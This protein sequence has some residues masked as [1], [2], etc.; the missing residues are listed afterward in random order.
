MSF[1]VSKVKVFNTCPY[2]YK[3]KY[4]DKL[5]PLPDMSP[6]NALFIGTACHEAIEHRSVEAGINS[7]KSHYPELTEDHEIEILKLETILPKAIKEIPEGEYEHC[8]KD[9]DGFIG[10]IDCLVPVEEGV[11]DLL[12]FKTSNSI[13]SYKKSEQV[14]VYKYYYEKL[15]GNKVRDLYYVFIPKYKDIITEGMSQE[16]IEELKKKIVEDLS[17]KDIHFEKIEF[18]RQQVNFFFARKALM[19]KAIS[20]EKRYSTK[21]SWCPY[22]KYCS[23]NGKD[24]SELVKKDELKE[25]QLFE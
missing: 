3:L 12:D 15:T 11:Y 19:D 18:N 1:S 23:T 5:E 6:N 10:Y 21:C 7:Y 16:N 4:I 9:P 8:L 22:Q 14:H 20:F 24:T 25:V 2:Q 17:S 13:S